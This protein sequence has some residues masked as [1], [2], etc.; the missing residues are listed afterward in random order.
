[1]NCKLLTK[2][3]VLPAGDVVKNM[4]NQKRHWDNIYSTKGPNEVSWT[5]DVPEISLDFVR[6]AQMNKSAKIIDIG[7]GDSKLVDFLLEMGFENIT[8]LDIS[9]QALTRAR[10]RLGS[11]AD[12]V[13]WITSDILDFQPTTLY[14]FWHD[15]A[16][17][18]FL[19]TPEQ[20]IKYLSIARQAVKENGNV[21][22]GTFSTEGP[23]KCSGLDVKQYNEET[24][25]GELK[26]GFEKIKCIKEKHI[27][28]FNTTQNFLFCNF[29]RMYER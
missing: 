13:Y 28:P 10:Q 20:V 2:V 3:V 5:Q 1:V 27:T 8:V 7:S 23:Q 9:K 16:A 25:T 19:T 15:R 21:A 29:K 12:K 24:L 11:K 17:F 4:E 6:A 14:D 22:I 18:H 26:N